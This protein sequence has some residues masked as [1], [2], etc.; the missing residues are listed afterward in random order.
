MKQVARN[1]TMIDLGFLDGC[2]Y[3]L[4]DRDKKFCTAFR[5]ILKSSGIKPI[6]LPP[7][8]PDLNSFVERWVLSVKSECLSKL[9]LFGEQSLR[10]AMRQYVIHYHQECN[11]QGLDYVIPFPGSMNDS[12]SIQRK[13]RLGGLLRF[14]PRKAA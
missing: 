10:R 9:V 5:S 2:R 1:R 11:H 3:V 6:R 7:K 4:M 12:G 8:S 13:D 14:Y